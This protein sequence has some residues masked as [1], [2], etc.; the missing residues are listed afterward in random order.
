MFVTYL[1]ASVGGLFI[2][3]AL[4]IAVVDRATSSKHWRITPAIYPLVGSVFVDG[5]AMVT[6]A[7]IP[8]AML[9]QPIL[10]FRLITF[11]WSCLLIAS[12]ALALV[13]AIAARWNADPTG[14]AVKIGSVVLVII[15]ATGCVWYAV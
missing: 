11:T 9:D 15:F 8:Y 4:V 10:G 2:L 14:R 12:F 5:M 7:H 3:T 13:S 1:V 6:L